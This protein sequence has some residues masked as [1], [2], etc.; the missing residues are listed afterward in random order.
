MPGAAQPIEA[1]PEAPPHVPGHHVIQR[2]HDVGV[3]QQAGAPRPVV[4][5]PREP[6]GQDLSFRGRRHRF[7]LKTSLIAAFS[8]ARSAYI[9]FSLEF[10]ASGSF[11]RLSSAI[12]APAYFARHW[13]YVA[14]L[15]L[16]C[17]RISATGTPPSPCFRMSTIWLSVNRDFRMGI[18]LAPESLLSECLRGGEA[19]AEMS[20]VMSSSVSG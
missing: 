2:G 3:A 17:R 1:L 8:S 14:L 19:Y 9:R 11:N 20:T 18:S 16:C 4:R 10:S 5:R 13:K 15:M 7:R 12:D 6:H